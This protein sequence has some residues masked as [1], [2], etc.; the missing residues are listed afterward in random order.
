MKNFDK[1]FGSM[2]NLK[3]NDYDRVR[4]HSSLKYCFYWKGHKIIKSSH[5]DQWSYF[6]NLVFKTNFNKD[7]FEYILNFKSRY[8]RF[9][10]LLNNSDEPYGAYYDAVFEIHYDSDTIKD[11]LKPDRIIVFWSGFKHTI[12]LEK[13]VSYFSKKDD[14]NMAH[15]INFIHNTDDCFIKMLELNIDN[16]SS[17]IDYLKGSEFSDIVKVID[18]INE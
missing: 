16:F 7:F 4:E 3:P 18:M 14:S 5:L 11:L 12:Y 1:T 15:I 17:K 2:I 13:D 8:F 6:L 9:K 10:N